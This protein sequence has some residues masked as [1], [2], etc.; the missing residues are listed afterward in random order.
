MADV[1]GSKEEQN[2][3]YQFCRKR[4]KPDR[5]VDI[6]SID[7]DNIDWVSDGTIIY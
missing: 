3:T 2:M 7:S 6:D 1:S 4:Q 5:H